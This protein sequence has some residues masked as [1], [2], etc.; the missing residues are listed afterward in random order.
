MRK[1]LWLFYIYLVSIA[2]CKQK[3]DSILLPEIKSSFN[4]KLL[5]RD[6]SL[7]VDSF[8]LVGIDIMTGK[9]SLIHQRFPYFHILGRLNAQIDSI[10]KSTDHYVPGSSY[11]D[12]NQMKILEEEKRYVSSEI[13][14]LNKLLISADS[15]KPVG[16]RA[17]YKVTVHKMDKFS[18]S[19]TIAY[20]LSLKLELSDWDRN[21]EKAID[22]LAVGRHVLRGP[23]N[24]I[25]PIKD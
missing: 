6:S 24:L 20:S 19:D 21:I 23:F 16:Y 14:S 17:I 1:D 22:S 10:R 8:Y 15:V 18:V 12:S 25:H 11:K 3:Q 4:Q 2:S 7:L 13:D 9:S 5:E